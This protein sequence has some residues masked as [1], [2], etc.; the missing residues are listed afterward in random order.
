[1]TQLLPSHVPAET[2][3]GVLSPLRMLEHTHPVY[4]LLHYPPPSKLAQSEFDAFK[5]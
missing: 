4:N 2:L 1:M 5:D 3:P